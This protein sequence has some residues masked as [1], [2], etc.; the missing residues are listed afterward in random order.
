VV[1]LPTK[2]R[3][4]RIAGKPAINTKLEALA[5]ERAPIARALREQAVE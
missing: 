5:A 2:E 1:R 4:R 3:P